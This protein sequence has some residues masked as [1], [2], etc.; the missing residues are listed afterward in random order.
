MNECF[1]IFSLWNIKIHANS[2]EEEGKKPLASGR[3]GSEYTMTVI[4][5]QYK[6]TIPT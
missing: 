3:D 6:L 4:K 5:R 1:F 2:T